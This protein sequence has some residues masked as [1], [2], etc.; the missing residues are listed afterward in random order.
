MHHPS[1]RHGKCRS[2]R[3]SG[4]GRWVPQ[5]TEQA[6]LRTARAASRGGISSAGPHR[7]LPS[8]QWP[9]PSHMHGHA[10]ETRQAARRYACET[11]A[12]WSSEKGPLRRRVITGWRLPSDILRATLTRCHARVGC[13]GTCMSRRSATTSTHPR[14]S[15]AGTTRRPTTASLASA[16]PPPPSRWAAKVSQ[17]IRNCSAVILAASRRTIRTSSSTSRRRLSGRPTRAH[18]CIGAARRR[19]CSRRGRYQLAPITARTAPRRGSSSKRRSVA[20]V[21][22]RRS[23]SPRAGT[24]LRGRPL[25]RA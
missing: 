18:G 7:R 19:C 12:P 4:V 20:C 21:L 10:A 16:P 11:L 9:P 13:A 22:T 5:R 23:V 3:G 2:H 14:R 6:Q 15:R 24:G 25:R 17:H 8:T 1:R